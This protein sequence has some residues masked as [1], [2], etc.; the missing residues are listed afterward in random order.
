[1]TGTEPL[2]PANARVARHAEDDPRSVLARPL[3]ATSLLDAVAD[4]LRDVAQTAFPL[5]LDGVASAR[6]SRARLVDQLGEHLVPRLTELSAPAVVVVS[7]STG[8]VK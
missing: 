3:A 2:Y 8:A 7:G 4:L 5:E 6:A 1:M